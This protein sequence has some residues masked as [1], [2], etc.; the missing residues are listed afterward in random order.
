MLV[1]AVAVSGAAWWS[2]PVPLTVAAAVAVVAVVTRHAAAVV[3]AAALLSGALGARAEAGVMPPTAPVAVSGEVELLRDPVP[4]REAVRVDVAVGSRRV[5]AWARS[6]AAAALR[7]RAAG[8]RVVVR[9]WLRAPPPDQRQR[10]AR[11]HVSARL[12][13]EEVGP[14]RPGNLATRAANGVRRTL[15]DGAT[16]LDVDRRAL[17]SGF[18]LG[19]VREQSVVVADDFRGA[20]LTHLLAVSGSNVAFVLALAGPLLGRLGLR[21]RWAA[22]VALIAFFALVTRFEPSV[23]RAS[24]MAAVACTAAGLGRPASRRRVLALAVTAVVL[25]DPFVVR[26]LA[27]QLSVAA[28]A[29]IITLAGPLAARLPGPRPLAD[30]FAVTVAA[31]VGVAPVLVPVFG[32]LPV[33]SIPANL[34]A[35]PAAGPLMS[36]GLTAGTVAGLVG[37][38]LDGV[39]HLPTSLLTAWV[40]GVARWGAGLPLGQ[41]RAPHVVVLALLGVLVLVRR[42]ER[43]GRRLTGALAALVLAHACLAP[44][45]GE[46]HGVEL[47][48]GASLWRSGGAVV[49]L[50][51]DADAGRVLDG[52]RREGLDRID[53]L[54]L[55][56]GGRPQATTVHAVRQRIDVR[57]V[58]APEG[59]AVRDAFV[60]V[61]RTPMVVGGVTVEAH[62]VD[63]VLEVEVVVPAGGRGA[64]GAGRAR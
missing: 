10:L 23:L 61:V 32:G 38:P 5:E 14:W 43:G 51:D 8:E 59:H 16:P 4:F 27:F 47:A 36:W 26:S 64:S 56:R 2:P 34:L 20:G 6:E 55:R 58:L 46:R 21:G 63:P 31:Q 60:P 33:S 30:S 49:V 52:L 39:L 7:A 28:S 44:V 53:V 48:R 42:R 12:G 29:G 9:G 45:G 57:L 50:L 3:L 18:V 22:T 54:A 13:I 41:L 15:L 40:A 19:D 11:R 62:T 35:V 1:L 24:A 25:V 37:P 17:F